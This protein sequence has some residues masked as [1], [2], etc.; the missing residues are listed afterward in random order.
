MRTPEQQE[1]YNRNR[2]ARAA[3]DPKYRAKRYAN[4]KR[5]REANREKDLQKKRENYAANSEK[6]KQAAREWREI[7]REQAIASQRKR[8]Q[9]NR[10]EILAKQKAKREGRPRT[11][12]ERNNGLKPS[13]FTVELKKRALAI[14]GQKCAVCDADF[15]ALEPKH[16][17]ADHC[18][19]TKQPRGVLCSACNLGLGKFKDDIDRLQRAIAY[20]EC[21]PLWGQNA[22]D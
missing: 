1:Q 12:R 21:P 18:H 5:W 15:N 11:L 8:Y 6:Y 7:N 13:G 9:D 2:V 4:H 17:H 14:Q 16:I 22:S 20:L 3:A 19:T 10:E